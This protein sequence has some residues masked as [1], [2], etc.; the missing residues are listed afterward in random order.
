[1]QGKR[2]RPMLHSFTF[3]INAP[4]P[5]CLILSA[6]LASSMPTASQ[7][8]HHE[9]SPSHH[10]PHRP[11]AHRRAPRLRPRRT[12]RNRRKR[13]FESD[14]RLRI[15]R[16]R[17]G[18]DHPREGS[19]ERFE[20]VPLPTFAPSPTNPTSPPPVRSNYASTPTQR[21]S[22]PE[23]LCQISTF[24]AAGHETTASALTW[25][26]YALVQNPLA[27][28]KLRAALHALD[29]VADTES[30]EHSEEHQKRLT[31]RIARCEYLDWV[32]KESLWVHAP[33]TNTMRVCM[34]D[35]DEIPVSKSG[36]VDKRGVRRWGIRVRKWDIISV[37]IQ[38][39]N[40]SGG[41]WGEDAQVF[42]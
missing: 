29:D 20:C 34:R 18:Q 41:L 8:R 15:E 24:L 32:V 17:W 28:R 2:C 9:P 5:S 23:I 33:V 13:R 7:Q 14:K 11:R 1:M 21:M 10:A 4:L 3:S 37:P 26:L 38:A 40:K 36:Y 30:G 6:M 35:E 25:C 22:V 27:Q 16:H 31:D 12:Q 42:R 39:I 19:V